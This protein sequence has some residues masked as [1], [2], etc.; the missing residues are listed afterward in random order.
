MY[1][2]LATENVAIPLK[3]LLYN[4]LVITMNPIPRS[5]A[6][7]I[8]LAL[9]TCVVAT[10]AFAQSQSTDATTLDAV[11]VVAIGEDP[12]KIASPY[13]VISADKLVSGSGT[14]GEALEGLPGVRADTFGGGASRPVIRGQGAPRVKVLSDSSSIFDASDIS[15]DHAVTVDPLLGE[16]IEVLRGPATLLYGGGAIGG[17]VNVLDNKIPTYIPQNGVEGRVAVRGNTV[18]NE[19]ATA[20]A[21]STHLGNGLVLHSEASWRDAHDYKVPDQEEKRADGTFSESK[22]GSVGLSWVTDQGYTGIAYSYREDDYGLPGHSDEYAD[23]HSHSNGK[24]DCGGHGGGGG[25]QHHHGGGGGHDD[26]PLIALLNRRID[27]RSEYR[28]VL[29]G[30]SRIR[31]RGA[32]ID[33]RHHEIEDDDLDGATTF[34]NKGFEG[35]VEVEHAPIGNVQ[36]VVG[37]QYSDTQFEA[38]G[39]EAFLP[40]VDTQSTGL[41]VVEHIDVS[42][43]L[44][45]ELGARQEWLKHE[46]VNDSRN[47]PIM[48]STAMSYSS[49][50][51][52]SFQPDLSLTLSAAQSQRLPH[53]Q[54]LYAR[55]VHMATNTYECGLLPTALTCGNAAEDKPYQREVSNNVE[56]LLRKTEGMLTFSVGGFVN[57]IDDYIYARTLD[58][59]DDVFRL[60]KYSQRDAKFKGYE[61]E[62]TWHADEGTAITGFTDSVSAK[63]DDGT[64]VPRIPATRYGARLNA[65][66]PVSGLDGELEFYRVREQKAIAVADYET[67]TPGYSMLNLSLNFRLPDNRTRFFFRAA[68]LLDYKVLNHASF[69]AKV[70]PQ[71]GRNLSVGMSYDF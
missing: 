35:R 26:V 51:I 24:L 14:L 30:V 49:A 13:S 47:R 17:V 33:Y 42:D 27:L 68:N 56:L 52:W 6:R 19:K 44:H 41:F 11:Q 15:P 25:G 39:P 45:V 55:G 59:E 57:E 9:L 70:V 36:G 58:V 64:R 28:D 3:I 23:C 32:H 53:A 54:E 12:S 5:L 21:V 67:V 31:L 22:N 20:A 62:V 34:S 4:H 43:Q 7:A 38:T 46:P 65:E 66:L 18:A 50:A 8:Q 29:P 60:I 16:R 63:F 10:P 37:V 71:P 69:L 48:D 1:H 2:F 40:Q 61:A